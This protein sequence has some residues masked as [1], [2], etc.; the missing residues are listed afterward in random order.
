M[1]PIRHSLT[2]T[3]NP[4]PENALVP[5]KAGKLG[6]TALATLPKTV[7]K[8]AKIVIG[9]LPYT[10]VSGVQMKGEIPPRIIAVVVLYAA[11]FEST[12]MALDSKT[13]LGFTRAA[14]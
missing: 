2:H 7:I 10:F 1:S 8:M 14:L 3:P 12:F 6:E 13:I 11:V 5:T 4:K 9:R